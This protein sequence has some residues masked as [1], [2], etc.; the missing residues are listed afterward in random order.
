MKA[1]VECNNKE[2]FDDYVYT[3][4]QPLIDLGVDIIKFDGSN[5]HYQ[6][7]DTITSLDNK[8]HYITENDIL[9][10]SVDATSKFFAAL[11]ISE[12]TYLGYPEHL[13]KYYL[14]DISIKT[15]AECAKYTNPYFIKPAEKVKLFTGTVIMNKKEFD[16]L[17]TYM[18]VPLCT[19]VYLSDIKN[20][21]TEY[22][23]FV[24]KNK[25]VGVKHYTGDYTIFPD[26][27]LLKQMI[28]DSK[29]KLPVSYTL[30]IGVVNT[31]NWDTTLIEVN[32]FWAIGGYGL[33]GKTYVRMLIDR[34]QEIKKHNKGK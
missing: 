22:R 11:G 10:G 1:F 20:F 24:H 17:H 32:D 5:K 12:P 28:E 31:K 9:I 14:R 2:Y 3:S 8:R 25:L 27:D 26:M 19:K 23:C 16:F 13:K 21:V 4:I 29:D 6:I 30:D 7:D 34:F 33:D 18:N 15:L